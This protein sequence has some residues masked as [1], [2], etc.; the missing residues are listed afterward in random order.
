[1]FFI[2]FGGNSLPKRKAKE[3]KGKE[4]LSK[5]KIN[6]KYYILSVYW[7]FHRKLIRCKET[8]LSQ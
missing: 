8:T 2:L 1:M 4:K 6:D 5:V 3:K 7:V